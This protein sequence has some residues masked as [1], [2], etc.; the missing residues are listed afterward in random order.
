MAS[1]ATAADAGMAPPSASGPVACSLSSQDMAFLLYKKLKE[2]TEAGDVHS[3]P[4]FDQMAAMLNDEKSR[5]DKQM[6]QHKQ[7]Q[8][9]AEKADEDVKIANQKLSENRAKS[10]VSFLTMKG[11]EASR[12]VAKGYGDTQ[13]IYPNT[14]M[15]NKS[16]NRRTEMKVL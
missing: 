16:K 6:D 1:I 13:P 4:L 10:V 5:Y 8:A 9:D 7:A 11:I 2:Q 14:T 12:L 3:K 15:E